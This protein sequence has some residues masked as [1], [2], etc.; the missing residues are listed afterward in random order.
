M[1]GCI[2]LVC[3]GCI[4]VRGMYWCVRDVLVREGCIGA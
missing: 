2:V 1:R 4:G 3:E